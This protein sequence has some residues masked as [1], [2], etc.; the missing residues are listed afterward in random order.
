MFYLQFS[1]LFRLDTL[2]RKPTNRKAYALETDLDF[3]YAKCS[4]LSKKITGVTTSKYKKI[5]LLI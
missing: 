3:V 5:Y 1:T 2:D 4:R